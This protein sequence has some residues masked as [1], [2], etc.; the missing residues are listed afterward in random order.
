MSSGN[1]FDV[2]IKGGTLIDGTNTPRKIVDVGIRDGKVAKIGGLGSAT[3]TRIVDATGRIV[4]PGVIDVHTHYDAAI[5]WDPYCTPSGYHGMTTAIVSNCGFGFAPCKQDKAVQERYMGMMETTEQI[6]TAALRE[7]LPFTWESFPEWLEVVQGLDKG[8]NVGS[9]IPLNSLMIFVMGSVEDARDRRPTE[10]E[11]TE[12]KRLLRE[13]LEAGAIGFAFSKLN[14]FNSHK[15]HGK[16]MPTDAAD[17][18]TAYALAEVLR[19]MDYGIIQALVDLPMAIDNNHIAEKLARISGRPVVQNIIVP[20]DHIPEQIDRVLSWL[21]HCEAEGLDVYSQALAFRAWNE[22]RLLDWN[23]WDVI[24]EFAEF[25]ECGDDIDARVA[26]AADLDWRARLKAKYSIDSMTSAGGP[27]ELLKLIALPDANDPRIGLSFAEIAQATGDH[28]IDAFFDI[29]IESHCQMDFRTLQAMS[30]DPAL[31]EKLYKHP[32]VIAGTS[33]GGAHIRFFSGGNF[34]TDLLQW[35]ALQEKRF[36]LEEL[37]HKMSMLPARILNFTDRGALLT[38]FAA[39]LM[40]YDP[41]ELGYPDQ[42]EVLHDLPGG[43]FRRVVPAFGI[44]LIMVNGEVT[45]ESAMK[46]TGATPGRVLTSAR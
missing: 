7:A 20:F 2:I 22:S 31:F 37:H 14:E 9:Y 19:E 6:P 3:A 36:T 10:A 16:P 44:D 12:M 35:L 40:I 18:S 46:S 42:Y 30:Q 39:D 21:D 23:A 15:D 13:A 33:D 45:F 8:V 26:V 43:E 11:L 29:A 34:S 24:P 25:T 17:E 28:V 1:G 27:L 38:G 32:R 41:S 5:F 4:A